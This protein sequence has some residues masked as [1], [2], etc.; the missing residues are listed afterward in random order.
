MALILFDLDKE[1][2]RER[3]REREILLAMP[4]HVSRVT[5][6]WAIC[7]QLNI[8]EY[9]DSCL[10]TIV[11]TITFMG[12]NGNMKN[13]EPLKLVNKAYSYD[14]YDYYYGSLKVLR[15]FLNSSKAS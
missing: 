4:L 12:N 2:E 7:G 1:R 9:L 5:H 11:D 13:F 15:D 10:P 8:S 3:E 6:A 14:Y